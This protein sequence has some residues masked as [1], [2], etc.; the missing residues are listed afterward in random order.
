MN[1]LVV[2]LVYGAAFAGALGLLYFFGHR[3]WY[4]HAL[5]VAAALVAG[6]VPPPAGW[7]G[8]AYDL[9]L[10]FVF[11]VLFVWGLGAPLFDRPHPF[12]HRHA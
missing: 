4:W 10:G 9:A 8:A 12:H 11:V 1:S 2:V 5:S 3:K 7:Q 6:L